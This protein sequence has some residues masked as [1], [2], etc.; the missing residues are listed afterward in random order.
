VLT[1]ALAAMKSGKP[2]T[3][4]FAPDVDLNPSNCGPKDCRRL[5]DIE[6]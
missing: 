1:K 2:I 5:I 6:N 3:I 4:A